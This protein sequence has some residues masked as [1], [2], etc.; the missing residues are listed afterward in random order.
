MSA[1][2]MSKQKGKPD[3]NATYNNLYHIRHMCQC[4]SMSASANNVTSL[5]LQHDCN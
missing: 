2:M 5:S 1:A 3:S 4:V